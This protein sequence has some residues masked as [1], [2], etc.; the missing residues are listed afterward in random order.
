MILNRIGIEKKIGERLIELRINK[1]LSQVAFAK[2]LNTGQSTI[3]KLE[4]GKKPTISLVE[5]H[6][7]CT[8][9]EIDLNYLI[10]GNNRGKGMTQEI[11]D[12]NTDIIQVM[13]SQEDKIKLL[14]DAIVQRDKY[15]ALLERQ[16]GL[17]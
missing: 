5:L 2:Q 14:E 16:L 17:K 13:N 9:L 11:G 4:N 7:L 10:G 3:T 1:G 6:I 8:D 15:I 12:N